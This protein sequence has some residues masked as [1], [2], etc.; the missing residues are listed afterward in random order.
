ME[1]RE[2]PGGHVS[3]KHFWFEINK[4][5]WIPDVLE[6]VGCLAPQFDCTAC[7]LGCPEPSFVGRQSEESHEFRR[8]QCIGILTE[9]TD[10]IV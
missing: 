9:H 1:F 8:P 10:D 3:T 7:N 2:F 6:M 4:S 5:L